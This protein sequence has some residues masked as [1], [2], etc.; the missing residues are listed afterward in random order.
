[1]AASWPFLLKWFVYSVLAL[2][3]FYGP[4]RIADASGPVLL[5]LQGLHY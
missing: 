3:G 1:M 5:T 2:G 4:C